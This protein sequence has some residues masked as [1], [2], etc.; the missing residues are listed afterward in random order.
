MAARMNIFAPYLGRMSLEVRDAPGLVECQETHLAAMASA[1][2][3]DI[4]AALLEE[5]LHSIDFIKLLKM[6]R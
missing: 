5:I 3:Q 1:K 4:L 2:L 6:R